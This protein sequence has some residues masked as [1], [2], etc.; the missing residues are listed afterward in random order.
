MSKFFN[1]NKPVLEKPKNRSKL[2]TDIFCF[3]ENRPVSDVAYPIHEIRAGLSKRNAPFSEK[4][5]EKCSLHGRKKQN[6]KSLRILNSCTN[7]GLHVGE[8]G[9]ERTHGFNSHGSF[10]DFT[11]TTGY[12]I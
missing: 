6:E 3:G 8:Q 12:Y 5:N 4:K 2:R 7:A 9:S 1:I 11:E 10:H